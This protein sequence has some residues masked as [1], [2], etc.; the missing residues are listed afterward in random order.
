MIEIE[1]KG[2]NWIVCTNDHG[3]ESGPHQVGSGHFKT[4]QMTGLEPMLT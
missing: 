1:M 2:R 4:F 3:F